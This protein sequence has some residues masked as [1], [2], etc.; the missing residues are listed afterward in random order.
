CRC[1]LQEP[2]TGDEVR[3]TL[4][5]V[6]GELRGLH[7]HFGDVR[8]AQRAA[9]DAV[10]QW[11][12]LAGGEAGDPA[13]DL[14]LAK[15]H[16]QVGDLFEYQG[17]IARALTSYR[18]A[19]SRMQPRA[20]GSGTAVPADLIGVRLKLAGCLDVLGGRLEARA[21]LTQTR[22]LVTRLLHEGPPDAALQ[23][24]LAHTYLILGVE[25]EHL[26]RMDAARGCWRQAR[27]LYRDLLARGPG[28]FKFKVG[29]ARSCYDLVRADPGDSPDYAEAVRMYEEAGRDQ[30]RLAE[31]DPTSATAVGPLGDTYYRLAHCCQL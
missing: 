6:Y 27:A 13:Y 31:E 29:L 23:G 9:E 20:Q 18:Q 12:C 5:E 24:H 1:L 3:R 8:Q 10:A 19:H 26:G 22:D 4:A 21:L 28:S 30:T 25:F 15:A 17:D 7:F 11:E 16:E 2:R 14:G